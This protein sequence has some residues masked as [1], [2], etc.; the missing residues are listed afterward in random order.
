MEW[1]PNRTHVRSALGLLMFCLGATGSVPAR[2]WGQERIAASK[3]PIVV[4]APGFDLFGSTIRQRLNESQYRV[5]MAAPIQDPPAA[6]LPNPNASELGQPIVGDQN[7]PARPSPIETYGEVPVDRTPQFLRQVT[8]LLS[9]G[10][11]QIDC[12]LTYTLQ[13]THFPAVFGANLVRADVRRRT[14]TVP[15]ALRYGLNEETQ[16]FLNTPLGWSDTEFATVL[17]DD[18]RSVGGIGDVSF[19]FNRLLCQDSRC[20]RSWVGT[21]RATAPT[22]EA[23]NPLVI[24]DSGLGNG[25]WRLGGDLLV[26]QNLDPVIIFY[27][28]GY[29]YSFEG[30][31]DGLDIQYGHQVNYNLGLGFAVN[32]RV[33]LSTAFLGSYIGETHANGILIP[34]SDQEPLQIRMAATIARCRS[35]LVEPFVTFGLTQTAPSARLGVVFTR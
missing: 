1:H 32:E 20:G 35:R 8:P 33:T 27:G 25:V 26:V 4:R 12:G 22:G 17:G 5:A 3:N 13:E 28:A 6:R 14:I 21:L 7:T 24:T 29:T 16:L 19:G 11:M 31:I 34:N 2:S 30:D 9:R 15:L 18:D 10:Q 23:T